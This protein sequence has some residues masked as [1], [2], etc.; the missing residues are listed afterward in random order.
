MLIARHFQYIC[1]E[2]SISNNYG[3]GRNQRLLQLIR[4]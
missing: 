3:F 1:K 4:K 2:L